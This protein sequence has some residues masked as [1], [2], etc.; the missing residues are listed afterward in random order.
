MKLFTKVITSRREPQ[1]AA[2][3][4]ELTVTPDQRFLV[5]SILERNGPYE[6]V[7][8]SLNET[9]VRELHKA[10]SLILGD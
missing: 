6:R 4:L 2:A 9:N 5:L 7:T 8:M 1:I 10:L 3:H